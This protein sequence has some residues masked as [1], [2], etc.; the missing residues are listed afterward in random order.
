MFPVWSWKAPVLCVCAFLLLCA[1]LWAQR[2]EPMEIRQE[3]FV[4]SEIESYLRVAGLGSASLLYPW[5]IRSFSPSEIERLLP[6]DS[7]HPWAERYDLRPARESGS[8]WGWIAFRS[9]LVYNSGFPFGSSDGVVWA[10]RGVT[11]SVLGG[12]FFRSG[13][14]LLTVAPVAFR[15]E[16]AAFDLASTGRSGRGLYWHRHSRGEIDLPQRFGDE[17]YMRIDPGESTL[18]IDARGVSAGISTAAQ[19]WGPAREYPLVLSNNAGGF[20]HV[21]LGT[22]TPL[23]LWVARLHTRGVWGRLSQSAYSPVE[24]EQGHRFMAGAVGVLSF[25]KLAGLE[26]GAARFYHTAWPE[27]GLE[28]ADFRRPFQ[29]ILKKGLL[30]A[31]GEAVDA[32][33]EN[34]LVSVFGR[35]THPASAFEVYGEFIRDD[36][37]YDLRH[38][39]LEPDDLSGYVVGLG[40]RWPLSNGRF[41]ALRA[42]VL[43]TEN[44]RRGRILGEASMI[45]L[46]YTHHQVRQGH[47]HRGQLLVPSAA[48]GGKATVVAADQ[49][50]GRGRWTA[51]WRREQR[52]AQALGLQGDSTVPPVDVVHS[53]GIHT[54]TFIGKLD[55]T[56][57]LHAVYNLD[58][59]FSGDA[60]NL[61]AQVQ[62]R[63][64]L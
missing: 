22:A 5:S 21:F 53:F 40:K 18:R 19:H 41:A 12:F 38:F 8:A 17:P 54:L 45:P 3:V 26:L 47:T 2:S 15:A 35:W 49:Y 14:L 58:R 4:G 62:V 11:A 24:E 39:L 57:G 51:E 44:V 32:R 6:G 1:P 30:V 55:V 29:G 16:N 50:H 43:N 34:Q 33:L 64:G 48:Y 31:E 28:T 25:P 46:L 7:L 36:H 63:V 13:P 20:P 59:D 27:R 60:F 52:D 37:S 61:H 23:N 10:G 42:E 56:S 9:K